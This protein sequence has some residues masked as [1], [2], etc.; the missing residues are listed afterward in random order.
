MLAQ[1]RE[2]ADR[3]ERAGARVA[4]VV[5]AKPEEV[6]A[7]CGGPGLTCIPDP[8]HESYRAMGFRNM[9][10]RAILTSKELWSRRRE[11]VQAGFVQDWRRTFARESAGLLLPG[12]ALIARGGEILWLHRGKHTGDLPTVEEMAQRVE[13]EL[14]R[15]TS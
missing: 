15:D 14:A 7:A 13:R 10:L 5:Q 12:A 9:S 3:I 2:S 4:C 6:E 8:R 11:A 1:L